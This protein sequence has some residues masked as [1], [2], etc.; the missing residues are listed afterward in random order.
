M[1]LAID[2]CLEACSAALLEGQ[3]VLAAESLP[4]ARGHQEAL[5]PL[6]EKLVA[7]AGIAF[8]DLDRIGVTVGPGSFTGL[9]VGL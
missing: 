6:V 1:V 2:T 8:S 7:Q 9:R 5:A 4:L 3:A